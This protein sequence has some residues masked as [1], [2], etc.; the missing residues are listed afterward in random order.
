MYRLSDEFLISCIL[1][2]STLFALWRTYSSLDPSIDSDGRTKLA[3]PHRLIFPNTR[4]FTDPDTSR[5]EYLKKRAR[6]D[7][8]FH[9]YLAKALFP[10]LGLQYLQDWND[11]QKMEVPFVFERLVIADR[12]ATEGAIVE[13]QPVY[14]PAF[15]LEGSSHWWEPVRKTLATYLGE[16]RPKAK[17]VVTYIYTQTESG[18]AKLSDEDHESISH[19]LDKMGQRY[20]YEVHIVSTQTSET[21]WMTKM[22]AIVKSSV[23]W[24]FHC[25]HVFF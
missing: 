1:D 12:S 19:A 10:Q 5:K 21:D 14:S 23:R 25:D 4:S 11:Y 13:G 9:P 3:Q 8:G 22:T 20:G 7:T 16:E 2:N 17:K 18:S 24:V 15:D 6:V